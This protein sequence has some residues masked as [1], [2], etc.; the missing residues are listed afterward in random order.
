[1]VIYNQTL[2]PQH[3]KMIACFRNGRGARK[4]LPPRR[5]R[6]DRRRRS[7]WRGRPA[8]P[9]ERALLHPRR[10][11]RLP[12][13]PPLRGDLPLLGGGFSGLFLDMMLRFQ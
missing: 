8:K 10:S 1:M 6:S 2:K 11:A 9:W 4:N 12:L 3:L 7:G 13:H 5:G